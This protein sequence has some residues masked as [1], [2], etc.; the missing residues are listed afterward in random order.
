[1]TDGHPSRTHWAQSTGDPVEGAPP[2]VLPISLDAL[3]HLGVDGEGNLFWRDTRIMTTKK[4][5]RLSV[6]QWI[7]AGLTATAAMVAAAAACVS[8][9]ADW[10][11]LEAKS[12]VSPKDPTGAKK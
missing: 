11:Q 12:A 3:N 1:M 9:Y 6:G 10:K 4:E 5:I 8:A 7:V 2:G